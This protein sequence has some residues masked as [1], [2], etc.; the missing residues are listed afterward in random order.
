MWMTPED[1]LWDFNGCAFVGGTPNSGLS[2]HRHFQGALP[3]QAVGTGPP[4]FTKPLRAQKPLVT[5]AI[6]GWHSPDYCLGLMFLLANLPAC[7]HRGVMGR[8]IGG[9]EDLKHYQA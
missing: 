1:R 6:T 8:K 7:F 2:M 4:R 9:Q 3:V 5:A